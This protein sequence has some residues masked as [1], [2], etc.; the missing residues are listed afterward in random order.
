M[1]LPIDYDTEEAVTPD[2]FEDPREPGYASFAAIGIPSTPREFD[3]T[4]AVEEPTKPSDDAPQQPPRAPRLRQVSLSLPSSPV[5]SLPLYVPPAL[6]RGSSRSREVGGSVQEGM[7]DN[8]LR[9]LVSRFRPSGPMSAETERSKEEKDVAT[10]KMLSERFSPKAQRSESRRRDE[11]VDKREYNVPMLKMLSEHFSPSAQRSD[12]LRTGKKVD[13]RDEFKLPSSP[14]SLD[15]YRRHDDQR[16]EGSPRSAR[17]DTPAPTGRSTAGQMIQ[18][19]GTPIPTASTAVYEAWP[20]TPESEDS[21][22]D[23]QSQDSDGYRYVYEDE[24]KDED[25][26]KNSVIA[27]SSPTEDDGPTRK[28]KEM[29]WYTINHERRGTAGYEAIPRDRAMEVDDKSHLHSVQRRQ[30]QGELLVAEGS[31]AG[32]FMDDRKDMKALA[33]TTVIQDRERNFLFGAYCKVMEQ[34]K[35]K[36]NS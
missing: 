1:D 6:P 13:G 5:S 9:L 12:S 11:K 31:Q 16:D 10:L 21:D 35:G 22:S 18:R 4:S 33:K 19:P 2:E 14:A 23:S 32:L 27:F 7:Q 28:R 3:S 20:E 36:R 24:D 34:I 26:D 30:A 25:E 17:E 8:E 15:H 29:P